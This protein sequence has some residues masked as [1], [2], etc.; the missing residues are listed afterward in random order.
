MSFDPEDQLGKS[1]RAMSAPEPGRQTFTAIA[2]AAKR[3][4][5]WYVGGQET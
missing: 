1:G 4:K 3:A 2:H 5:L